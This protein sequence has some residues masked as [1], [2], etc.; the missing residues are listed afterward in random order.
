MI[1]KKHPLK[2]QQREIEAQPSNHTRERMRLFNKK[3]ADTP[4]KGTFDLNNVL[5]STYFFS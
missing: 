3:L 4:T 1:F 2:S 5:Q